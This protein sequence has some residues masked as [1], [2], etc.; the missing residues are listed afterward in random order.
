[1]L[2]RTALALLIVSLAACIRPVPHNAPPQTAPLS[3]QLADL[4]YFAGNWSAVMEDPRNGS[5]ATLAYRVEPVL[6]GMWLEGN[7]H[8]AEL[9]VTVR[10]LWGRDP[11]SGEI[12]RTIF[13]SQG[14]H[15]V[16]RS[17]GWSGDVLV[18]EGD[19]RTPQGVIAVRET[20]TRTSDSAFRAVWEMREGDAWV[21]Y[22]IEQLTRVPSSP[23]PQSP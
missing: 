17:A 15:G 23:S 8:S 9:N 5:R 3:D 18:L 19:A 1:M 14:I 20:I 16:V 7:G 11:V 6:S 21:T 22:S 13:D 12:V 10:D 4:R 2:V